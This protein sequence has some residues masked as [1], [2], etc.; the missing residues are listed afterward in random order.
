MSAIRPLVRS[1]PSP[2]AS[3][4]AELAR[5]RK[6]ATQMEGMFVQQLFNAMRETVPHDGIAGGSPGE[7]IF[8]SLFDQHIAETAPAKW[9]HGLA[10]AIARQMERRLGAPTPTSVAA[11][12]PLREP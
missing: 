5:L 6:T 7:E 4:P 3:S 11:P 8:T 2:A 12:T 1:A 10:D 9:H